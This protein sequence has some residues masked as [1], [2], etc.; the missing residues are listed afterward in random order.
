MGLPISMKTDSATRTVLRFSTESVATRWRDDIEHFLAGL[1]GFGRMAVRSN[2]G[3]IASQF[4]N[5]AAGLVDLLRVE[6][7]VGSDKN[8]GI[9]DDG[10]CQADTLPVAFG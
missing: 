7:A 10:L 5:Q 9:V 6:P 1:L 2:N 4:A 8:I 3:V